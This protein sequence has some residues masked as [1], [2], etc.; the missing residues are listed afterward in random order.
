MPKVHVFTRY[1]GPESGAPMGGDRFR[2][3]G[4]RT[5]A[6]TPAAG[7]ARR[8]DPAGLGAR[9]ASRGPGGNGP[10]VPAAPG[11]ATLGGGVVDGG[12]PGAAAP[13]AGVEAAVP[14]VAA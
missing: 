5:P 4:E 2:P 11:G 10:V 7:P 14:E 12:A 9:T 8:T 3:E 1:G 6:T 13:R